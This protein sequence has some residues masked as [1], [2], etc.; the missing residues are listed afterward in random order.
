MGQ[1]RGSRSR[2]KPAVSP[3]ALLRDPRVAV[4]M[5]LWLQLPPDTISFRGPDLWAAAVSQGPGEAILGVAVTPND[6]ELMASHCYGLDR[7]PLKSEV[8]VL[9]LSTSE[10]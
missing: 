2:E 3:T 1:R 6:A 9:T 5:C 7:V 10:S 8:E 4:A